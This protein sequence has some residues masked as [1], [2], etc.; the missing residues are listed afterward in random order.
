MRLSLMTSSCLGG[1]LLLLAVLP[2]A[3]GGAAR[4]EQPGATDKAAPD[5]IEP[6]AIAI[7]KASCDVLAGAKTLAFTALNTYEKAARNGQP[8]FYTTLNQVTLQRPDKLRVITPG[9]GIPDEFYYDGKTITAYVPSEN[10]AARAEA[11]STI[12]AMLPAAWDR[13]AIY[14]P[15]ADLI[16][17]KPCAVFE[18]HGLN[19][20]FYVGQSKVVAGTTTDIVAVAGDN[21]QGEIWI[22][23]HDHLPRLVR[24]VYPHEPAH[25][26]YQTEYSNWHIN[27]LVGAGAFASARAEKA[28]EMPFRPP[29]ARARPTGE[30]APTQKP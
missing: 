25:A 6:K 17:S 19:S 18:E 30:A 24:V 12:D 22:G 10:L 20:A 8:L 21:V 11:P 13:A 26:L 15:F 1:M 23:A 28:R 2:G 7:L 3:M 5:P 4:A 29:G 9:D 27:H 14:F 16:M